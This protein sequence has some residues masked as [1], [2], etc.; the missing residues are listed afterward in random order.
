MGEN[1]PKILTTYSALD[2]IVALE[3]KG[4]IH[5][6]NSNGEVQWKVRSKS[7]YHIEIVNKNQLIHSSSK[8]ELIIR[9]HQ[10]DILK[11]STMFPHFSNFAICNWPKQQDRE[12]IISY[13]HSDHTI[14]I[15]DFEGNEVRRFDAKDGKGSRYAR[16]VWGVPVKLDAHTPDYFAI[17]LKTGKPS[18]KSILYVYDS[19]GQL[20]FQ[21]NITERCESIAA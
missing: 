13:A 11:R 16:K 2:F 3:K 12:Y 14:R 18:P 4:G 9:D 10:G 5:L 6:L 7:T 21:E 17:L 8:D 19:T 20:V 1:V 15:C